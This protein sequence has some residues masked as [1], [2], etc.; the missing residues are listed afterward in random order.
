MKKIYT[1][2]FVS[3]LILFSSCVATKDASNLE[4]N[5]AGYKR[6]IDIV[7]QRYIINDI[8]KLSD[9]DKIKLKI[10]EISEDVNTY[11][12]DMSKLY[13]YEHEGQKGM[14][15]TAFNVLHSSDN[16]DAS[17]SSTHFTPEDIE[18]I[19][20][21]YSTIDRKGM[22]EDDFHVFKLNEE[23]TINIFKSFARLKMVILMSDMNKAEV[24]DRKWEKIYVKFKE[25]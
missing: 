11:Q 23:V 22:E 21:F 25:I 5:Y 9:Q 24:Y 19:N 15:A 1:S 18:K 10:N 20:G 14:V 3:L 16:S 12:G 4:D 2:F 13:V 8:L 17:F 7:A 6:I